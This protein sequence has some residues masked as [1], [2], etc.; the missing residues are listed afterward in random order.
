M[1]MLAWDGVVRSLPMR[2]I[3][4]GEIKEQIVPS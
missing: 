3:E 4:I 1:K 2:E